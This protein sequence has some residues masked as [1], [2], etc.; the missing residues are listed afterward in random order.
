MQ[1]KGDNSKFQLL[2]KPNLIGAFEVER[3]DCLLDKDAVVAL[4]NDIA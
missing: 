3:I 2:P 1:K 4:A